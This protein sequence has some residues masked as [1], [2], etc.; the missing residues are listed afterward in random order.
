MTG[1]DGAYLA[2]FLLHKGYEVY[3]VALHSSANDVIDAKLRWLGIEKDVHLIDGNLIDLSS[4]IRTFRDIR[5]DEIY[6]LAAQS[7]VKSSWNQPLLTGNVT[8]L[9]A[10]HALEA[11]RYQ[12]RAV[13]EFYR[14]IT[15][16][17]GYDIRAERHS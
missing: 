17:S 10:L 2:Q 6:N 14:T 9:G 8:G 12:T 1:Q 11:E 16:I 5:P 3:G 7:F 4:L 13:Q 15:E